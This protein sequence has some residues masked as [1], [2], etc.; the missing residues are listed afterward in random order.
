K[1]DAVE[2]STEIK[3]ILASIPTIRAPSPPRKAEDG[4]D[5]AGKPKF[6]YGQHANSAVPAAAISM[7]DVPQGADNCLAGLAFVFTGQLQRIGR[8][9]G[10]ALVKQYG[11][12]VTSAP[13]SKTSYVVLGED[14]GPKKLETIKKFGL[15]V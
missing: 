2:D 5:G 9:Q 15:Q 4:E 6:Q 7:N 3:A 11:G 1:K 13:S 10:Q 12:K 14:A 8:E